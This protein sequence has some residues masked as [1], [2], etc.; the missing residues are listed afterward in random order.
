MKRYNFLLFLVASCIYCSSVLQSTPTSFGRTHFIIGVNS[1]LDTPVNS[2]LP[3]Q[4]PDNPQVFFSPDHN[5]EKIFTSLI[6]QEQESIKIA[7]Y[8]FTNQDIAKSLMHA[9]NRGIAIEIITDQSC[10]DSKFNKIKHLQEHGIPIFVYQTNQL[11]SLMH[12][13]FAIFGKNKENKRIVWTGSFNFTRAATLYNQENVVILNNTCAI[14]SYQKHFDTLKTRCKQFK[15]HTEN[16]T[17]KEQKDNYF[18]VAYN[19]RQ[20]GSWVKRSSKKSFQKIS[21]LWYEHTAGTIT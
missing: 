14:E 6:D 18:S 2:P 4:E 5:L 9:A 11:N 15:K 7:V 19:A 20:F 21:K 1:P 12:N 16:G 3:H 8:F 13:K 10:I 17:R